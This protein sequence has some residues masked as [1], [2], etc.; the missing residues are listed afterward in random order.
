MSD[1]EWAALWSDL[2]AIRS[3]AFPVLPPTTLL[4]ELGRCLLHCGRTDLANAY[5]RGGEAGGSLSV[6]CLPP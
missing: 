1:S 2:E 6:R 5:L 3:A 4:A